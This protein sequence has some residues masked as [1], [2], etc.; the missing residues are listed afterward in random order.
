MLLL[1]LFYFIYFFIIFSC[2]NCGGLDHH[3]KECGLP[4]QPKKCHY[5]QSITHMVAQCPHKA[6]SPSSGSQDPYAST[7]ASAS[8]TGPYL[9][10]PEEE[11]QCSGS[12]PSSS[13]EEPPTHRGSRTQR[14]R[15]SWN[16][17]RWG[18]LLTA[19]PLAFILNQGHLRLRP[20]Q[21]TPHLPHACGQKEIE[22]LTSLIWNY[23][24][25]IFFNRRGYGNDQLGTNTCDCGLQSSAAAMAT[26]AGSVTAGSNSAFNLCSSKVKC[27]L[28]LRFMTVMVFF[29]LLLA[30]FG[31]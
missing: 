13:P 20:L 9:C 31:P 10:P 18:E 27:S 5:C 28:S 29:S 7:S 15:K 14:W 21:S 30:L 11:Q 17:T 22:V 4:P 19:Q 24:Y 23:Y 26:A 2:Y 8:A 12:S 25:F 16:L 3:A 1:V 6:L